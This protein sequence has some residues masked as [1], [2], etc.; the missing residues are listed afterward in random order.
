MER[1]R[2]IWNEREEPIVE[3]RCGCRR[4]RDALSLHK[5]HRVVVSLPDLIAV[6]PS[7]PQEKRINWWLSS[8]IRCV[9][10]CLL[11]VARAFGVVSNVGGRGL[12][13]A[14]CPFRVERMSIL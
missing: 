3:T 13:R 6:F 9:F 8:V 10:V 2:S 12:K 11:Q 4:K 14:I 7:A 5:T 1:R